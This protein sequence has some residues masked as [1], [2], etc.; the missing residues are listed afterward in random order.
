MTMNNEDPC[1]K[2]PRVMVHPKRINGLYVSH[3]RLLGRQEEK[4]FK[5]ANNVAALA[6]AYLPRG[7]ST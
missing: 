2:G 5:E 3:E 4:K 7:V 1:M 6:S